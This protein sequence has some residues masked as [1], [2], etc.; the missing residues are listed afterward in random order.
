MA[1]ATLHDDPDMAAQLER[2]LIGAYADAADLGEA[3]ATAGRVS[4]GD[5]GQWHSAWSHTARVA[6]AAGDDAAARGHHTFAARGYLRAAEYWRQSY[7]FLRHDLADDR[8]RE[9]YQQQRDA[10]G[11]AAPLLAARA[12]PV[13]IPFDPVPMPGYLLQPGPDG[14]GPRPTVLFP[15]GFDGTAEEIYK[16]GAA[17]ATELG[18]NALAWDGPGQGGMLVEH[19]V[20][21]RPDFETVLT[22]V[23]DWVL[24]QPFADRERLLLVGRSL[25][26]YLAPRGAS[27]EPRITALVCDPGQFD[28]T[29]RFAASFG[30]RE[31]QQVLD[32]DPD[33]D[34]KLERFLARPRD[35]EYYGS[36]MA[37][38][39][40]DTFGQWL[41][42]LTG[43]TLAG[44]AGQITCPTL[45]TEGEGDFASQSRT[46]FDA[47]GCEKK[48]REFTASAGAGGH[49]E[50]LG[51]RLWQQAAFS[52]LSE[53]VSR[54]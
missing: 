5:Y 49:C 23:T 3:L 38:M 11:R 36:R 32:A 48:Y 30:P 33:T 26:G 41:R 34:A 14:G 24:A 54:S 31:W 50:G 53:I 9:A 19:G 7:F 37:A 28:F 18:W 25:G 21:M 1:S 35:R 16:Y 22:A 40:A 29:S 6:S 13:S 27:G 10:F 17:V 12:E 51:Q 52:W 2:T 45:V 44:R 4:P 39:G 8:V 20:P 15:G 42:T 47:L 46:L 43:Y